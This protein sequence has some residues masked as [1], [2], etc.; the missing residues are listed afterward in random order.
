MTHSKAAW[1][2]AA[3]DAEF[4]SRVDL[5][6]GTAAEL[7]FTPEGEYSVDASSSKGRDAIRDAYQLRR[8]H[9]PRTSR[10]LSSNFRVVEWE[11]DRIV[12]AS[13][14]QI[15]AHDG[16]PPHPAQP[17]IVAD[18]ED[19]IELHEGNW[20]YASRRLTTMFADPSNLPVIPLSSSP[21]SKRAD[22]R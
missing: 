17:M 7:L 9:G 21:T 10:H 6:S 22:T 2:L 20:L 1:R 3:L 16:T 11:P 18:V 5:L 12:G 14:V 13:I 4:W 15:F 8:D 19:V